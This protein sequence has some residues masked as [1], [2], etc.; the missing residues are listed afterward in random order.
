MFEKLQRQ[1]FVSRIVPRQLDS[2]LEHGLGEQRHPRRT[3]C[4]VHL[5]AGWQ[6]RTAVEHPDIVEPE[7]AGLEDVTPARVLSVAPPGEVGEELLE[8][9]P[10]EPR[11]A[12]AAITSLVHLVDEKGSPRMHWRIHIAKLPL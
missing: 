10:E 9:V 1:L 12:G 5:A 3:V 2:D 7:K 8:H 11:V 6:R 4:L